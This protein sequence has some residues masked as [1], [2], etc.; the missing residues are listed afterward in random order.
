MESVVTRARMFKHKPDGDVTHMTLRDKRG[1][2]VPVFQDPVHYPHGTKFLAPGTAQAIHHAV[3]HCTQRFSG[4][5]SCHR[6]CSPL[7]LVAFFIIQD[8]RVQ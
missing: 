7:C 3:W 5:Q 6:L 1:T 4:Q 2:P 8:S